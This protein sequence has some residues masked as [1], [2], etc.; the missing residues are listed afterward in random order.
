MGQMVMISGDF[1]TKVDN[2]LVDRLNIE[3]ALGNQQLFTGLQ[4]AFIV[5]ARVGRTRL[6]RGDFL[7]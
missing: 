1:L 5:G 6:R 4:P 2:F 7:N 3:N